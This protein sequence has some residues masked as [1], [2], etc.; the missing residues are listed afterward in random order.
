MTGATNVTFPTSGTLSTST[1][2]V[3]SVSGTALQIDVATGTTTPVISIDV[4]YVGQTSLTT[5][6]T[7][8]TGTWAASLVGP[9]YGGTGVNNGAKTITLGG[10]LTTSGAFASTFTM[11]A[12]TSVTFPTSGTLAT[13][14]NTAVTNATNSFAFNEQYQMN[15]QDYSEAVSALG[16]ISGAT[17]LNLQNG[18]VFTAT[19]TGAV[20]LSIT[21][22]PTSGTCA[23]LSLII[24]NG[25]SHAVT[26]PT[27]TKWPGGTAPTLTTS[28]TDTVI[29]YTVNGGTTWYFNAAGLAYA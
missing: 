16:S 8:S 3:T 10:N 22:V 27:G 23:S 2:T 28:G 12:A 29:G 11:T 26:W 17:A 24:T 7:I 13:T 5:L 19:V 4:G 1:G 20:T 6:G 25:G 14:A 15:I 9:T 18:N 21:N